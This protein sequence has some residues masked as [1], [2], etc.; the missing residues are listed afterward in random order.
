MRNSLELNIHYL[1]KVRERRERREGG[2]EGREGGREGGR[3]REGICIMTWLYMPW[4][5]Y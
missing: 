5:L 1:N 2:R 3:E 4:T